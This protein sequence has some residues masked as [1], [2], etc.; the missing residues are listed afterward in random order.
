MDGRTVGP[1]W[2]SMF[3]KHSSPVH[4]PALCRAAG[5]EA[6]VARALRS[7]APPPD[8]P[9]SV[10]SDVNLG[11]LESLTRS[12]P[13]VSGHCS[14]KVLMDETVRLLV[15]VHLYLRANGGFSSSAVSGAFAV[16]C[17]SG[18]AGH[19]GREG[20]PC[21]TAAHRSR[22]VTQRPFSRIVFYLLPR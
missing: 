15:I 4:L 19:V 11:G 8:Q 13:A 21:P 9:A 1:A 20:W 7:Q 2:R 18:R 12:S 6:G 3:P 5:S 14:W 16:M 10:F 17:G 22:S